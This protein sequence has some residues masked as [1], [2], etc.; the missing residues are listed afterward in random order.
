MDSSVTTLGFA[1]NAN[2]YTLSPAWFTSSGSPYSYIAF[3]F[4]DS[5]NDYFVGLFNSTNYNVSSCPS[6]SNIPA[7]SSS[8]D[9]NLLKNLYDYYNV[10]TS[11]W[12]Y[13]LSYNYSIYFPASISSYNSYV[14]EVDV[15]HPVFDVRDSVASKCS[16]VVSYY[17]YY[18][19]PK[20]SISVSDSGGSSSDFTPVVSAI[21]M[22]PATLIVLSCFFII[23]RMFMNRKLRA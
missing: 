22:I 5:N 20:V 4:K 19:V 18:L 16:S 11:S 23:Y 9:F 6:S 10:D 12:D 8:S 1:K 14:Y 3:L 15:S 2:S 13:N 21:L 17:S 7:I